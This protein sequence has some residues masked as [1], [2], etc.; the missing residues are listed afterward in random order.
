MPGEP[1]GGEKAIMLATPE[2]LGSHKP[3]GRF[4]EGSWVS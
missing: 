2:G 4:L 1:P 3:S